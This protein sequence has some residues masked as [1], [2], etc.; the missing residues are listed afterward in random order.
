MKGYSLDA[1]YTFKEKF[2]ELVHFLIRYFLLETFIK[3]TVKYS[4]NISLKQIST[5]N[6]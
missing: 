2:S 3:N 5:N 1:G 4:V 6:S